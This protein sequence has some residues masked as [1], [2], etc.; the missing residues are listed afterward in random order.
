MSMKSLESSEKK[1]VITGILLLVL[2]NVAASLIL[3][4]NANR[5]K[6]S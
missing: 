3:T 1:M 6:V 5:R 2:I 4:R